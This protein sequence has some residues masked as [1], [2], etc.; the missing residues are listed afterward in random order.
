MESKEG[1]VGI[2]TNN[3][4]IDNP[5][6]R[7]MRQSLLAFFSSNLD[8]E[9]AWKHETQRGVPE[10]LMDQNVFDIE[11]GVSITLMVK[12]PGIEKGLK[13]ADLGGTA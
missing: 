11:Q 8:T 10:N 1:V 7:G 6:F 2:I 5:T 12:R 13:Y 4:F 3:S 9:F